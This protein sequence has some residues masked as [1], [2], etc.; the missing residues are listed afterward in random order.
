MIWFS[1]IVFSFILGIIGDGWIFFF[2]MLIGAFID[3]AWARPER[4]RK[5]MQSYIDRH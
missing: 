3:V 1:L 4:E 5:R 2:M